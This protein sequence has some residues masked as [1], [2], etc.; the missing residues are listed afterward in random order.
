VSSYL[1]EYTNALIGRSSVTTGLL[2]SVGPL[3]NPVE[4]DRS[5]PTFQPTNRKTRPIEIR[6][7]I[8]PMRGGSQARLVEGED[9]RFYV[10][11]FTGNPQGNRTLVNEWITQPIMTVLGISTPPV[12]LL[13]LPDSLRDET[14]SFE[15]NN[16]KMRV[17]G[18]WHLGSLCPVNPETKIIFDFLPQRFLNNVSNLDDFAKVFVL[19]RWL[20]QLDQR[21]AIFVQERSSQPGQRRFRAYFVDHGMAFAGSAWDLREASGHGLYRDRNVY[22]LV[23]MSDVCNQTVSQI[24]SLTEKEVFSPLKTLPE[25]WLSPG[26]KSKLTRLLKK[27]LANRSGLR[28]LVASQL[29]SIAGRK[30]VSS[31]TGERFAEDITRKRMG[32]ATD[33]GTRTVACYGS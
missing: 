12:R 32:M 14:L 19:D 23:D 8:R 18:E 28:R 25:S 31:I 29:D 9:G 33:S 22:S 24:E 13:R 21:Q 30:H 10:A 5:S 6:R 1:R 15:V 20:Y 11:K 7:I 16:K 26:S 3:E 2:T 17:E 27:L 4:A